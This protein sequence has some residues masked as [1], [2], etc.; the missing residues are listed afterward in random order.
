MLPRHRVLSILWAMVFTTTLVGWALQSVPLMVVTLFAPM[1]LSIVTYRRVQRDADLV[2]PRTY[3]LLLGLLLLTSA[4]AAVLCG[5]TIFISSSGPVYVVGLT[6]LGATNVIV[7]ILAWRAL[8]A[9]STRGAALAGLVAVCAQCIA[10]AIDV[11]INMRVPGFGE[12]PETGFALLAALVTMGTGSLACFAALVA[13][14]PDLP[15]VPEA[16]VVD[17]K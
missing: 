3:K 16:R 13:F 10:M 9:P 6:L 7:A 14:G 17:D 5:S 11:N 4:T 1:L 8:L 15:D 2:R 12:Q